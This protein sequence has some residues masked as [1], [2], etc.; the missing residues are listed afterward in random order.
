MPLNKETKPNK[1]HR[2]INNFMSYQLDNGNNYT[3][4]VHMCVYVCK[5]EMFSVKLNVSICVNMCELKENR[6]VFTY[7]DGNDTRMLRAILNKSWWQ[8]PTKHQLYGHLP[9]IMKTIQVRRARHSGH[10]W[11]RRDELISDVLL[12]TP[13]YGRAKAGRPARPY[14]QQL[15]DDTGCSPEDLPEAMNDRE[16]WR[17]RVRDIRASDTTSWWWWCMCMYMHVSCIIFTNPSAQAGYD[18]RSIFKRSF[19]GL[20]SEFFFS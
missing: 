3:K 19:T 4:C 2:K 7:K 1:E 9:P 20:N 16:K 12:W 15:C 11:R 8:H 5:T 10:Y 17:E 18:T 13:A 14:I 6:F